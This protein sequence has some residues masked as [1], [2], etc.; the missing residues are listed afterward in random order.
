[1]VAVDTE[2]WEARARLAVDAEQGDDGKHRKT[3]LDLEALIPTTP[4]TED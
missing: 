1:M 4:N 2:G 3:V